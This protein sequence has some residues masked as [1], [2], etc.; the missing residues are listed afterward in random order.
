MK[1]SKIS[2]V[3]CPKWMKNETF[4]AWVNFIL[5]LSPIPCASFLMFMLVFRRE[6]S[7]LDAESLTRC[8]LFLGNLTTVLWLWYF[9][10][11]S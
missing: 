9:G 3:Y 5:F 1:I 8:H 2:K 6:M 11:F 7:T 4:L 10:V